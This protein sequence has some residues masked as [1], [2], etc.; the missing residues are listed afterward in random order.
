M[1]TSRA[2]SKLE[3]AV[4][5]LDHLRR[6][7]NAG[8]VA[9]VRAFGFYLS[10]FL[11]ATYSLIVL[12][13]YEAKD[14][15]KRSAGKR[16]YDRWEEGFFERLSAGDQAMWVFMREQR[17]LEVHV[18]EGAEILTEER[19][20]ASLEELPTVSPSHPHLALYRVLATWHEGK[21]TL[22]QWTRAWRDAPLHHF[23]IEGERREVVQVCAAYVG[24]LQRFLEEFHASALARDARE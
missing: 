18:P 17:R 2:W 15:L 22:P 8:T 5:F 10:A 13:E 20:A 7:H 21:L 3:E 9:S 4:F 14:V 11:S 1:E 12:L 23:E 24:L 19:P 6:E 16:T